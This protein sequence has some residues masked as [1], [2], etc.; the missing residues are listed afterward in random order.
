MSDNIAYQEI[1]SINIDNS[2]RRRAMTTPYDPE[3]IFCRFKLC[4]YE[5]KIKN[6]E[7]FQLI[8]LILFIIMIIYIFCFL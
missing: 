4:G 6:C 3:K 1:N 7:C 2:Q 8:V 5:I